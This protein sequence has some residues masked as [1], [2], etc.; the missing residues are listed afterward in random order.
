MRQVTVREIRRVAGQNR[1]S[2]ASIDARLVLR[3]SKRSAPVATR[4]SSAAPSASRVDGRDRQ[5]GEAQGRVHIELVDAGAE[6]EDHV[7]AERALEDE[8][9]LIGAAG[10]PVVVG[11]AV[12]PVDAGVALEH[13]VAVEPEESVVAVPGDQAVERQ[14]TLDRDVGVDGAAGGEGQ[15]VDVEEVAD[16][17]DAQRGQLGDVRGR[18][19]AR[20]QQQLAGGRQPVLDDGRE[21]SGAATP[22]SRS[23]RDRA[24]ASRC[25][26]W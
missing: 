10:Q 22:P 21:A 9:V 8:E 25:P 5:R 4:T 15:A 16:H 19:A 14:R 17:V 2:P 13:V 1:K 12:E 7:L 20:S 18:G 3:T 11:T 23:S 6:V 26:G 24:P